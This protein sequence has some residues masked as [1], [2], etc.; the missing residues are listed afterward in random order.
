MP[1]SCR[2][3]LFLH[4]II[5]KEQYVDNFYHTTYFF[6]LFLWPHLQ[7]ME[8]LRLGIESELQLPAYAKATAM[9]DLTCCLRSTLELAAV[10][11]P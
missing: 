4:Y 2:W 7:H 6:F 5:K 8:V 9:P 11:D 3:Y 1:D 10:P